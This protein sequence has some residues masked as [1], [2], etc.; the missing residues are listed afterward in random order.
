MPTVTTFE[1][2]DVWQNAVA[3]CERV[4]QITNQTEIKENFAL[5]DQL[6]RSALSVPSNIA[7]GF[8]RESNNQFLYF[9]IVAKGS[10]GELRTQLY[11][12]NRL[13]L[14]HEFKHNELKE[15]CIKVSKQLSSF[16]KYL[17]ENKKSIHQKPSKLSKPS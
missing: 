4:F 11:I 8:E 16:I 10:C 2:L 9:L 13:G 5:R 1:E 15:D 14:I 12:S 6:R 17:R 7:E 3:L